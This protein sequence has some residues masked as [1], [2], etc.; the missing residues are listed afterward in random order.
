MH[1]QD[2]ICPFI[3]PSKGV[4]DKSKRVNNFVILKNI[5]NKPKNYLNH[6]HKSRKIAK[7]F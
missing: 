5:L 4:A 2:E 1:F 7:Q 6:K 3:F